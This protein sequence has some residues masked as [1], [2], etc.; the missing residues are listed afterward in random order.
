MSRW[1][2]VPLRYRLAVWLSVGLALLLALFSGALFLATRAYVLW[3]AEQHLRAQGVAAIA[4]GNADGGGRRRMQALADRLVD[5]RTSAVV[6]SA[7]GTIV[8]RGRPA[9]VESGEQRAAP[10]APRVRASRIARAAKSSYGPRMIGQAPN[11]TRQLMVLL[12]LG[13]GK[14]VLQLATPL[15][16]IDEFLLG[17]RRYLIAGTLAAAVIG[18][19]LGIWAT[20]LALR[21]LNALVAASDRVAGGDWNTRLDLA[22]H[23]EWGRVGRA[24]NLMVARIGESFAAQQRFLADAAHELRTPLT[25]IGGSI[26]LLQMGAVADQPDKQRRVLESAG[27]EI[28]RLGR[29][30]NNLLLLQT[31]ER[32]GPAAHS[33]LDLRPLL[34]D[35]VAQ[36]E[37]A[38]PDHVFR[39][40][41][42]VPLPMC[43]DSD[44]LRQVTLNLLTNAYTYTPAG[45]TITVSG[46]LDGGVCVTVSDTGIGIAAQDVP[47]VGERLYR[48][49]RAR[50][51]GTGGFGLGLSIVNS[52]VAA[53]HGSVGIRSTPGRG[54]S[55][56]IRFPPASANH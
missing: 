46:Q 21:P 9:G 1:R 54:T 31:L 52:I 47:R 39:T 11:G 33:K 37:L 35:V 56:T 23:G 26:E 38:A 15:R 4:A 5:S 24:F 29:L 36:V 48:V 51:R 7:D 55:V 18:A 13:N 34:L 16:P 17:F 41:L 27:N 19:L 50:A 22:P 25:A 53:H 20:S 42:P 43:G 49:D 40:L 3:Q 12:P 14:T 2:R 28:D 6:Y 44:Q 45:G 8:A 10:Q 32:Q 30:V